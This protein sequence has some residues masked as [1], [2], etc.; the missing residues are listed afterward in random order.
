MIF[1]QKPTISSHIRKP[2]IILHPKNKNYTA[3]KNKKHYTAANDK[4]KGPKKSRA[5]SNNNKNTSQHFSKGRAISLL[6]NITLLH[7]GGTKQ[8]LTTLLLQKSYSL[9]RPGI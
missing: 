9:K 1:I 8:D 5:P 6:K 2:N 4:Q 3:S 7:Y